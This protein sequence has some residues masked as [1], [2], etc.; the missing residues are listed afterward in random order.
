MIEGEPEGVRDAG[1]KVVGVGAEP[2][3][4]TPK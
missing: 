1:V 4:E 2:D 3:W